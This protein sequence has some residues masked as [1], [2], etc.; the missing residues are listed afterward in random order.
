LICLLIGYVFKFTVWCF[1]GKLLL[2]YN[3]SGGGKIC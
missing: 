1:L 3:A 2:V